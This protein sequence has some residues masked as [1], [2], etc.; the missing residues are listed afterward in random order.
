MIRLKHCPPAA[1]AQAQAYVAPLAPYRGA[2]DTV[3]LRWCLP[4]L[5]MRVQARHVLFADRPPL[6]YDVLS[7]DVGI[8][9]GRGGVPG[10]E[11]H[12]TPVKP[13]DG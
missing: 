6:P 10:A 7:I 9:P 11:E 4:T 3:L 2:V 5:Y 13:I 12:T 8:T 1:A